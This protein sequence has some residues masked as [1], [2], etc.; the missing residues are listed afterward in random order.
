MPLGSI[1]GEVVSYA[2]FHVITPTRLKVSPVPFHPV[3]VDTCLGG[4]E[5]KM[6]ASVDM[7]VQKQPALHTQPQT[8]HMA[9]AYRYN[10]QVAAAIFGSLPCPVEAAVGSVAGAVREP[11]SGRYLRKSS[12]TY[13]DVHSQAP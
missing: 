3:Y 6:P 13:D 1:A 2:E 12:S 9:R 5:A 4:I 8:C 10:S 7:C 11:L